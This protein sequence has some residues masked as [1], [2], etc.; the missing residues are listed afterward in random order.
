[1]EHEKIISIFKRAHVSWVTISFSR[2][3]THMKIGRS[4]IL[5]SAMLPCPCAC[6][7]DCLLLTQGHTQ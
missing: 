7:T 4:K 3:L 1:M 2:N 5:T 6:C